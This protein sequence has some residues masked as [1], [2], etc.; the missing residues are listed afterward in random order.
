[1]KG[2]E[3]GPGISRQWVPLCSG[4][5]FRPSDA[6]GAPAVAII[7]EEFARSY[8]GGSDPIG[9]H[10]LLPGPEPSGYPAEIVG[11]VANSKHRT[12]GETQRAAVYES[13]L[14]RGN[15]D[16]LAFLLVRTGGDSPPSVRA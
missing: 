11:I 5:E 8:F 7:N 4:R 1:M 12:I 2:I 14:Q 16:R 3:S 10:L 6:P 9:R 13:F 15:R